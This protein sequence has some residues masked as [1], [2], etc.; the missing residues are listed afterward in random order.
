VNAL[1]SG[2]K[3]APGTLRSGLGAP[4]RRARTGMNDINTGLAYQRRQPLDIG[5]Y[6]Q[7]ILAVDRHFYMPHVVISELPDQR[8][9]GRYHQRAPPRCSYGAGDI[10]SA[11][12]CPAAG[13]ETRHDLQDNWQPVP[14]LRS[15]Y[16][17]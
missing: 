1:N 15:G 2:D 13:V 17:T 14:R 5:P 7:R 11:A 10:N 16:N 12:L 6:D 4:R 3:M 8:P 9:T